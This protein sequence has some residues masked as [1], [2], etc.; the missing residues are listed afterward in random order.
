MRQSDRT[1][2]AV[3]NDLVGGSVKS[4]HGALSLLVKLCDSGKRCRIHF[5]GEIDQVRK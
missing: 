3:I 4:V 2:T 1:V 5:F